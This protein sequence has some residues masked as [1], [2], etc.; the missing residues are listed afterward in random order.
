MLF[1]SLLDRR[2]LPG[3]SSDTVLQGLREVVDGI[4]AAR[5]GLTANVELRRAMHSFS[6]DPSSPLVR[7]MQA[8]AAHAFG[9]ELATMYLP[10]GSNA[11]YAVSQLGWP[12][13]AFGPGNIGDLGPNEHVEVK[14]L[15]RAA[16]VY[17]AILAYTDLP[18]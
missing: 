7:A 17:A 10:F 3:E 12:A 16:D 5:P 14:Q 18:A 15:H 4:A 9:A 2:T 6:A 13:A 11:G 8:A 1:R